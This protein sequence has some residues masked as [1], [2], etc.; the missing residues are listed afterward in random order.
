MYSL[1]FKCVSNGNKR[2]NDSK[3]KIL[4]QDFLALERTNIFMKKGALIFIRLFLKHDADDI[5]GILNAKKTGHYHFVFTHFEFV[6][7]VTSVQY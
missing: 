4:I 7:E 3:C 5:L 2:I 1:L 6:E